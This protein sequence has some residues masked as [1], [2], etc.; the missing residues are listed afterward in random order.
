MCLIS[1]S[2]ACCLYLYPE[3]T[4]FLS[5]GIGILTLIQIRTR[6]SVFQK[7]A[8]AGLLAVCVAILD[9]KNTLLFLVNQLRHHLQLQP[10]WHQYYFSFL[11]GNDGISEALKTSIQN[12]VFDL[13][14]FQVLLGELL[15][16]IPGIMG[17]FFLTP[18]TDIQSWNALLLRLLVNL[19]IIGLW[20][21][22]QKNYCGGF[23]K[24][25]TPD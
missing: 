8:L 24:S 20:I 6:Y 21:F 15:D 9:Y 25:V 19:F 23:A 11:F 4:I 16:V 5:F 22:L 14:F 17:L 2:V 12:R 10:G 13:N 7:L 18:S 3:S 1:I